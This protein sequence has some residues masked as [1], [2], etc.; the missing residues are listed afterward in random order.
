MNQ[1]K[2]MCKPIAHT[3]VTCC[4]QFGGRSIF[5]FWSRSSLYHVAGMASCCRLLGLFGLCRLC[6]G[7]QPVASSEDYGMT[8]LKFPILAILVL[9][10][11]KSFPT[12]RMKASRP[13]RFVSISSNLFAIFLLRVSHS[14]ARPK[15]FG[16]P[17]RARD[18]WKRRAM[19]TSCLGPAVSIESELACQRRRRKRSPVMACANLQI[20]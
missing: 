18:V 17:W 12:Q 16:Y 1:T 2:S 8:M 13:S 10:M 19:L 6:G 3:V 20:W 11:T 15:W 7:N 5:M 4:H 9:Q 14:K